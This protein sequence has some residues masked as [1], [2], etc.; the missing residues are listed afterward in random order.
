MANGD[1][2]D[3]DLKKLEEQAANI[4][5]SGGSTN[6]YQR[7]PSLPLPVRRAVA[8]SRTG[9]TGVQMTQVIPNYT[10]NQLTDANDMIARPQYDEIKDAKKILDSLEDTE[11]YVL[12]KNV[13]IATNGLYKPDLRGNGLSDRDYEAF[14]QY[15]LRTANN[16]GRTY[17]VALSYMATNVSKIAP[18]DGGGRRYSV[19]S[20]DD[21]KDILKETSLS[22]LGY[23][24]DA[25]VLN[26]LVRNIQEEQ[27]SAQAGTGTN[28]EQSASVSLQAVN[29]LMATNPQEAKVQ[30]AATIAE[31]I[32]KAIVG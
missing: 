15:I 10:G 22:L 1:K 21:I 24:P 28:Y 32:K 14:G 13:S 7:D 16:M 30:G 5:I 19:S 17:D 26:R 12:L 29:E 20:S 4:S 27:I 3:Q 8:P 23:I 6:R 9:A 31:I 2:E 25:K 18:V 11:R